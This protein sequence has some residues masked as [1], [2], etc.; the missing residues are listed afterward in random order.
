MNILGLSA[1]KNGGK[2]SSIEYVY[3][4]YPN[5]KHF[6]FSDSLKQFCVDI[7]GLDP[8][9]IYGDENLKNQLT[10]LKWE[11]FPLPCYKMYNG[12]IKCFTDG[13]VRALEDNYKLA[14][15][16]NTTLSSPYPVRMTGLMTHRQV[17]A[18]VATELFRKFDPYCFIRKTMND[19]D[20]W[21]QK[22]P[23]GIAAISD[24]R[25]VNEV[26]TIQKAGGKVIRLTRQIDDDKHLSE[27]EL[28]N[29][30]SFD[31]LIDNQDMSLEIKNQY[32]KKFLQEWRLIK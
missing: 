22:N 6:K 29:Y 32:I 2:D 23:Y 4:I 12:Q 21:L 5:V 28:D 31:C 25:F 11:D 13:W 9:N 20:F 7:L 14:K 10:H 8:K 15:N 18:F 24:V 30:T 1:R 16:N 17:M 19:I 26:H 3:K 27:T